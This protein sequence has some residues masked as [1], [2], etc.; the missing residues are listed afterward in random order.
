MFIWRWIS[1][2]YI[3]G[4]SFYKVVVEGEQVVGGEQVVDGEQVMHEGEQVVHDD[5]A[6]NVEGESDEDSEYGSYKEDNAMNIDFEDP[7][8][9]LD[10]VFVEV[11]Q[12]NGLGKKKADNP[13]KKAKSTSK[14]LETEDN[15]FGSMENGKDDTFD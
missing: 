12:P 7:D 4:Y 3:H 13:K 14:L 8:D 10:G 2:Y 6:F 11:E 15:T 5:T 1:L 9:S